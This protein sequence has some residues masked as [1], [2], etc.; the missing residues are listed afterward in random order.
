MERPSLPSPSV[1]P[2]LSRGPSVPQDDGAF[3]ISWSDFV[4]HFNSLDICNRSRGIRDLYL[5]LH[6]SD[7]W[8]DCVGPAKGCLGGCLGYWLMCDGCKA[9]YCGKD[10]V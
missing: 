6:E 7:G 10:A 8:K 1:P 3:W 9:L 5:D 4:Q 2:L